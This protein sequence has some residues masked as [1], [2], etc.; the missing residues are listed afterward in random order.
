LRTIER[1]DFFSKQRKMC[2]SI[3]SI[4]DWMLKARRVN[5]NSRP[6]IMK[7]MIYERRFRLNDIR[8]RGSK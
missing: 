2:V 3:H 5:A 8:A 1:V 7:M 6:I 4:D